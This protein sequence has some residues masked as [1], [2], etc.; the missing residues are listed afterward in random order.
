MRQKVTSANKRRRVV[1]AVEGKIG[2]TPLSPGISKYE[3]HQGAREKARRLRRVQ[4]GK[5]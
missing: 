3:P 5:P 2:S 4:A 1:H